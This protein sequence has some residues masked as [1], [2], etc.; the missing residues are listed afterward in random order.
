VPEDAAD[1]VEAAIVVDAV[2]GGIQIR[3]PRTN[4]VAVAEGVEEGDAALVVMVVEE[5]EEVVDE[6][7]AAAALVGGVVVG[8]IHRRGGHLH[9]RA[10]PRYKAIS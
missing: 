7:A 1:G 2:E 8:E 6:G 3:I 10:R 4:V 5:G 9:S